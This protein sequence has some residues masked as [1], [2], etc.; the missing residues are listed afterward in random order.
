MFGKI[1]NSVKNNH[2]AQMAVCCI[3]PVII[4]LALQYTGFASPWVYSIALVACVGSHLLMMYANTKS[5]KTC[6]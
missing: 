6:H 3:L 1:I 5:G 2:F 4:I